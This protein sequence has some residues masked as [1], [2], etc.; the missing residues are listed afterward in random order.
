[1]N[2]ACTFINFQSGKFMTLDQ[3]ITDEDYPECCRLTSTSGMSELFNIADIK[4]NIL[5]LYARLLCS[6]LLH[7]QI[8]YTQKLRA[9]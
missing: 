6:Q 9:K 4:G 2:D 3:I 7:R 1:M 5:M 8:V